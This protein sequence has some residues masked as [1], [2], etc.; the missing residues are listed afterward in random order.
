MYVYTSIY[1]P[2]YNTLMCDISRACICIKVVL[3]VKD[4]YTDTHINSLEQYVY[5]PACVYC[6]KY[7]GTITPLAC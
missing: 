6:K 2:L 4:C 1:S 3:V 7:V 5:T